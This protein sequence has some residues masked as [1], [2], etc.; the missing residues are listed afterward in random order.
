MKHGC[1]GQSDPGFLRERL[2]GHRR[3]GLT[4]FEF[5]FESARTIQ[6]TCAP[7]PVMELFKIPKTGALALDISRFT[8]SCAFMYTCPSQHPNAPMEIEGS[9]KTGVY[10]ITA[11]SFTSMAKP[12]EAI[13][14]LSK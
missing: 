3:H 1:N 4:L 9:R 10:M 2:V 12:T 8:D 6:L 11:P 14:C 13:C 7:K 5:R